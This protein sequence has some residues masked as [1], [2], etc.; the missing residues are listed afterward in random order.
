MVTGGDAE[1]VARA[2]ADAVGIGARGRRRPATE[3]KVGV[4]EGLRGEGRVVAVVGDGIN[5]AAALAGAD[6]GIAMGGGTDIAIEA[7]DITLLRDD[8][9]TD[10]A[11]RSGSRAPPCARSSREPRLGVRLQHR[12]DPAGGHGAA[13]PGDRGHRHGDVEGVS[14]VA[15][16]LRLRRFQPGTTEL[17]HAT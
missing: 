6:L 16:S 12:G 8:L 4:V 14:V 13:Q 3:D 11:T 1:P 5:D 10:P 9:R 7:S 15:N 17:P 2:V